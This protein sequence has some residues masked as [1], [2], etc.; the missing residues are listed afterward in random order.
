MLNYR[1]RSFSFDARGSGYG[2]GEGVVSIVLKTLD[3]AL[4][5]G[6]TIR[7][8]IRGTGVN[9]DGK[10]KGITRPNPDAQQALIER[11]HR[12]TRIKPEELAY[13]E[14]HGTGT[15]AGDNLECEA[16]ANAICTKRAKSLRVGSIKSN[17]G[18]LEASS[19]LAGL[20]KAMLILKNKQVVPNAAFRN[21]KESLALDSKKIEVM[22]VFG[23]C[24]SLSTADFVQIPQTTE[25]LSIDDTPVVSV[26][27]FGYGGTNAYAILGDEQKSEEFIADGRTGA[28]LFLLSAHSKKAMKES[29]RQLSQW[30]RHQPGDLDM[31]S[32]AYTLA[33]RRSF[34]PW[35]M[36]FVAQSHAEL[37]EALDIDKSPVAIDPDPQVV[38]V[39]SGQGSQWARMV[40]ILQSSCSLS[41]T[42]TIFRALSFLIIYIFGN[43]YS[44]PRRFFTV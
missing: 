22:T 23:F 31:Q 41:C 25:E 12:Q 8:V 11:V 3:R 33:Q 29:A 21:P 15:K 44:T 5:D 38:F 39:F 28:Q 26:S 4:R 13:L 42:Y 16:I 27:S 32:V 10:T 40:L 17:V 1:G 7:A 6:D 18:H 9:Q 35:R 24:S 34:M 20:L 14:A 37:L 36:S 19:G 30:L 43:L 2:R